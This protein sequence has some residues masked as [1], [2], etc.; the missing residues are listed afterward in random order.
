MSKRYKKLT[1][2]HSNDMHGDFLAEKVHDDLVGGVSMLSG[3]IDSVREKEENVLYCIAGDMFRGSV[4]DSEFAGLSTIEIMNMLS[5]DVVTVGNHETDYGLAHL[6]FIEK[7]AKFPIINAN[8]YVTI[9]NSRLF[10]PYKII[11]VDG[12]KVLFIGITTEAVISNKVNFESIIGTFVDI[13]EAVEEIGKICNSVKSIDIDLTVLLTH[14]GWNEDHELAKK[15]DTSWGIDI[16][17]GGHSHTFIEKPDVVNNVLIAQAGTG[18]DQVGRFDLVI[19]TDTNSVESYKW[20]AVPINASTCPKDEKIEELIL[21]MKSK[22]DKKYQRVVTRFKHK[23]VHPTRIEQTSLGSTFADA[24]KDASGVDIMILS[25][26]CIRTQELGPIVTYQDFITTFPYN[27][28]N[29][30]MKVKGKQLRQMFMYIFRDETWNG[31]H[32]EFY[33]V[34][35]GLHIKY[36]KSKHEILEFSLVDEDIQDEKIYTVGLQKYPLTN[37]EECF[38]FKKEEVEANGEIKQ[39]SS[40]DQETLYEKLE[41]GNY[42]ETRGL[43]RIEIVD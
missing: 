13:N 31:E 43:G 2:L 21:D 7:C 15:L 6:L 28:A 3:Y 4:I 29:Y 16:I 32:T 17:I 18:T 14:I 8:L 25:S 38:G 36:S 10:A 12:M 23:L 24:F 26:G 37:F 42:R 20:E 1:L 22:T 9:S 5:P 35:R 27:A 19:D 39:I 34:S 11:E 33:Q 40:S 41:T 30:V